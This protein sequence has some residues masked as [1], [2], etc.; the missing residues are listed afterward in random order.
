MAF[1]GDE[2]EGWTRLS[3]NEAMEKARYRTREPSANTRV[4]KEEIEYLQAHPDES[5]RI[6]S[7]GTE[8][9]EKW[10]KRMRGSLLRVAREM[11]IPL[12]IRQEKDQTGLV[13]WRATAEEMAVRPNPQRH[14]TPAQK[15]MGVT[16]DLAEGADAE[17]MKA[18][19]DALAF[20][21]EDCGKDFETEAKLNGHKRMAHH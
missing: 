11:N 16:E 20:T 17:E 6:Q 7:A 9:F 12:T 14:P 21:C 8:T 4:M 13:F 19:N 2:M 10:Y 3:R 5:T 15:A 18:E 1:K